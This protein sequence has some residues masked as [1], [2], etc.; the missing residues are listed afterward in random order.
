MIIDAHQHF[1]N[2]DRLTYTWP[3]ENE[4]EIY[5][6]IEPP[7]LEP[8]LKKTGIQKTVVVQAK[9]SCSET[10]YLLELAKEHCWIAGVVGWVPLQEPEKT[11][12]TIQHYKNESHFKGVRHLIH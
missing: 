2:F 9:D 7:E 8:L 1:W 6:N 4:S 5:R 3:T 10:D 12:E 11:E